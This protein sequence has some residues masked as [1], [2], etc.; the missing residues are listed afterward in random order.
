M[1]KE[2]FYVDAVVN[3][4]LRKGVKCNDRLA[5]NGWLRNRFHYHAD[6][7]TVHPDN[8]VVARVQHE[9]E[10]DLAQTQGATLW[11]RLKSLL[12]Q[13]WRAFAKSVGVKTKDIW[14]L[15]LLISEPTQE[16]TIDQS[17]T[18]RFRRPWNAVRP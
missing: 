17:L 9:V 1:S 15:D 2:K 10:L 8:S 7:W 5:V 6:N 3:I 18:R 14:R 13:A 16:A 4:P 12:R 11:Q